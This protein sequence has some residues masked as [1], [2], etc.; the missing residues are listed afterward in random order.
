MKRFLNFII[1]LFFKILFNNYIIYL[2]LGVLLFPIIFLIYGY[3]GVKESY[4]ERNDLSYKVYKTYR[5][6]FYN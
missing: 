2:I 6:K 1:I 5:G 4:F 3:K